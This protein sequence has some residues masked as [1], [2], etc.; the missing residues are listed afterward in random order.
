MTHF[1]DPSLSEEDRQTQFDALNEHDPE[2]E[3]LKAI[4]DDKPLEGHEVNYQVTN[5]G[6]SQSYG[7]VGALEGNNLAYQTTLI[8][9]LVWPGVSIVA[10]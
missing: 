2:A 3:R 10:K 7:Q 5:F 9:S 4:T 6:S 1:I 8:K